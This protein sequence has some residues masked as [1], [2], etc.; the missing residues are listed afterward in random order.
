MIVIETWRQSIGVIVTQSFNVSITTIGVETIV[1]PT[2]DIVKKG[3]LIG[4]VEKLGSGL[5]GVLTRRKQNGSTT[6]LT[7]ITKVFG[8]FQIVFTNLI[9]TTH[10]NRTRH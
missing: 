1:T 9:M 6:L 8:T 4:F 2:M 5:G 10:V 7:T 3:I